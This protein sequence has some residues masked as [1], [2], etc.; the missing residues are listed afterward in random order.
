MQFSVMVDFTQIIASSSTSLLIISIWNMLEWVCRITFGRTVCRNGLFPTYFLNWTCIHIGCIYTYLCLT[1]IVYLLR[2]FVHVYILKSVLSLHIFIYTE[3]SLVKLQRAMLSSFAFPICEYFLMPKLILLYSSWGF[4]SH[5]CLAFSA[6]TL[7]VVFVG[8][9][10]SL[11][12]LCPWGTQFW[13]LNIYYYILPGD[14]IH[15]SV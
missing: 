8:G 2:F 7:N 6:I 13:C 1:L 15:I 5:Q 9:H 4:R 11:E 10:Y 12:H 3:Y 14:F